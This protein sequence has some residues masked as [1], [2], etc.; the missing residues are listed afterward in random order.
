MSERPISAAPATVKGAPLDQLVAELRGDL[1][2]PGDEGYE[3]ARRVWN[4]TIDRRPA[5]IARCLGVADVVAA[6]NVAREHDL[7]VAVRGGGHN[8]AGNAV[9]NGGLV[10]DLSRMKGMRVDPGQRTVLA[11]PGATWG[12]LDRETQL[13][14]LAT[15]GGLV[16]TTGIAG[17]TLG[18]GLG[19]LMRRHGLACDNL[20]SVDLVTADGRYL[21]A[22]E[23]EH[24]DLF[25]GVR[26]GG[27][28]F[29]IVTSFEYR[30]H[31]LGSVLAGLVV[32]PWA[33]ARD[34]LRFYREFT[35]AAP[36]DLTAHAL[37][38]TSPDGEPAVGFAVCYAGPTTDGVELLRPLRT[39]GRPA[40]DTIEPRAYLRWQAMFDEGNAPGRR[41]YWKS[42]HLPGLEDG[43]IDA[44]IE[45]FPSVP[46]CSSSVTI[47]HLG[48]AVRRIGE[49][50]TAYTH[51]DAAYDFVIT[52]V[53]DDPRADDANVRWARDLFAAL[54]PY[55]RESVYVNYL[56]EEGEDRVRLAYGAAKYDRLVALKN[57]YDPTN[58][59][60]LNQN[61]RPT[62]QAHK[63]DTA[64]PRGTA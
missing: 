26:G 16:S 13:F 19:W 1:L 61:I 14:G 50:D 64:R 54:E 63:H 53:W 38:F 62:V 36:D 59:F 27:G 5:A 44:L 52:S 30:L 25:W 34:A 20:L 32:H 33:A 48:G 7:L 29:G 57:R 58:L 12:D 9:C 17:F 31:P 56:G 51:R 10:I 60:R 37:V 41:N 47:E 28:N 40:A 49:A 8:V 22:S 2:R 24:A 23:E 42:S 39:W 11:Q 18:G 3:A 45:R 43:L 46:S 4:A 21:T 15:T 55:A 35:A 6:V